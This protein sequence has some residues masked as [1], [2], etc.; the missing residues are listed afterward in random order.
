MDTQF[1]AI[2]GVYSDF[3]RSLLKKGRLPI[4]DTGVGFWNPS[5]PD[6]L[7]SIFRRIGLG[8]KSAFLDLGSGDGIAVMIASLFTKAT[9]IEHDPWLHEVAGDIQAKLA[10]KGVAGPVQFLNQDFMDHPLSGYDVVYISP[11]KPLWRGVEQKVKKELSGILVV[12]GHHFHPRDLEE[13]R[14]F[15]VNGNRVTAYRNKE[16][17]QSNQKQDNQKQGRSFGH[18]TKR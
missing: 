10:A 15:M 13:V 11:D 5:D 6:E 7:Y 3:H 12:H 8:E 4:K 18:Q 14:T 1:E 2:K 16:P 9:G 17:K